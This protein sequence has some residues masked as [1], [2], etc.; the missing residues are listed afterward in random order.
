MAAGGTVFAYFAGRVFPLEGDAGFLVPSSAKW[1]PDSVASMWC[2]IALSVLCAVF[3]GY[4]NKGFNIIRHITWLFAGLFVFMQGAFPSVMG[5]L[6]D[7]TVMCALILL[8]MVPLFSSFQHPKSTREIYLSFV[9]ISAGSLTDVAY[10]GYLVLFLVG[11]IQMQCLKFKASLAVVLGIV[12]PYWIVMGSGLVGLSDFHAPE[13][14]SIFDAVPDRE[15]LIMLVYVALTMALGVMAGVLN[16]VKV[17]SYNAR[18]RAYN[19][20]FLMLFLFSCVLALVD[21]GRFAVYLPVI[22]LSSA[23]Q[24]GH[25]FVINNQKRSY[26]P[27]LV[28]LALYAGIY[29]WGL[30]A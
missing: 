10:L 30:S 28:I 17:Y 9:L 14:V 11:C 21:Y 12:T 18:T 26:I 19:G 29:A 5:R 16:L 2:G 15:A 23:F 3:A 27:I 8:A 25:F 6:Y 20:F 13:F 4:L 7:G 1:I 24:I 22:N